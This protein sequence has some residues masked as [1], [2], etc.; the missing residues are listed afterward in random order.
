QPYTCTS[1]VGR[2]R[3]CKLSLTLATKVIMIHVQGA[4]NHG[5]CPSGG[6]N[7]RQRASCPRSSFSCVSWCGCGYSNRLF[8]YHRLLIRIYRLY[9]NFI[10]KLLSNSGQSTVQVEVWNWLRR[11]AQQ[12]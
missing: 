1:H 7:A 11:A 12:S 4:T 8:F 9:I 5:H 10:S 2:P 6:H 3:G